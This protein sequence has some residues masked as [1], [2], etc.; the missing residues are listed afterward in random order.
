MGRLIVI[1]L[2]ILMILVS[3]SPQ[4]RATVMETW[5]NIRPA[6]VASMDNMYAVIRSFVAGNGSDH[7]IDENP[8]APDPNFDVIITMKSG[9]PL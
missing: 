2:L 4:A 8:G 7:H 9:F 3:V 6:V 1:M 5:E